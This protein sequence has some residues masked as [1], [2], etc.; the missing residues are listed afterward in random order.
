MEIVRAHQK[1]GK[2]PPTLLTSGEQSVSLSSSCG[3]HQAV[4]LSCRSVSDC[5]LP[6]QAA[7]Q[8][9]SRAPFPPSSLFKLLSSPFLSSILLQ[10]QEMA[11]SLPDLLKPDTWGT[12]GSVFFTPYSSMPQPKRVSATSWLSIPIST[13][14]PVTLSRLATGPSA[15]IRDSAPLSQWG[16]SHWWVLL[17]VLFSSLQPRP[18][19]KCWLEIKILGPRR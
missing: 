5:S 11:P 16:L 19:S 17:S 14:S 1:A 15:M 18:D 9:L 2:P 3:F 13:K 12:G 7:S 8:R 4:V 10:A 6:L